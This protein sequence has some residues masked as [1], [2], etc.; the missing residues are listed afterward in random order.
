MAP[1]IARRRFLLGAGAALTTLGS[2]RSA[3]TAPAPR[4][5]ALRAGISRAKLLGAGRPDS[6]VWTYAYELFHTLRVRQG[7]RLRVRFE[8][9]L[10]EHSS[11]H[12]HG[13]RIPSDVDGV[14]YIS[15]PPVQQGESYV[16]EFAPPDAGT[17]FFHPHCDESGQIGRGLVGVLLV[18]GDAVGH[19]DGDHVLALKDW[20]LADDGGFLPFMTLDGAAKSGTY[21]TVRSVNGKPVERLSAP[22]HGD[23]RLRIA[24]LDAS[25]VFEI[26]VEGADAAVI[27][28]D[29]HPVPPFALES[30]TMGPAQRLDI[31][32]RAPAPGES[33]RLVDF[34][35]AEPHEI[36][37]LTGV[38]AARPHTDFQPVPLRPADVPRPDLRN[39]ERQTFRLQAASGDPTAVTGDLAPDDPLARALLDSLCAPGQTLWAINQ[40]SWASNDHRQLPPPLATLRAG[41]SYVWEI[42]NATQHLH[43]MHLHG[44]AFDVLKSPQAGAPRHLADTV[45]LGPRDRAE[46]AFVAAPGAWMFHCHLLEHLETGMMGWIRVV[47]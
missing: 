1:G 20:R 9:A 19:Y 5:I 43:P 32:V 18:E 29:G 13:L 46:I 35:P 16:Y 23:V 10:P 28:I 45:L 39:A 4:E 3:V 24:A 15:Q 27:A 37:T 40:Q 8:N 21:G 2:A 12:W 41:R 34:R 30:W 31:V 38:E 26:G 14:P 44:H 11:V 36:A 25:R 7:E 33:A 22:A 47:A 6:A 17:Y 42:V